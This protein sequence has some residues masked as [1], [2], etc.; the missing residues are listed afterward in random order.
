MYQV[1]KL[2][3]GKWVETERSPVNIRAGILEWFNAKTGQ[4]NNGAVRVRKVE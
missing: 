4:K 1:C 3:D 2:E